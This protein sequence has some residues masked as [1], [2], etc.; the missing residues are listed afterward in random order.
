MYAMM[1]VAVAK[2]TGKACRAGSLTSCSCGARG[3]LPASN[4]QTQYYWGCSENIKHGLKVSEEFLDAAERDEGTG[5][6]EQV[7]LQ[8]LKAGRVLL[9]KASEETPLKCQCH[10]L[11]GTCS[12]KTCWKVTP[13]LYTIAQKLRDRYEKACQVE[14]AP[15]SPFSLSP[16]LTSTCHWPL[17][18]EDLVF[19]DASP[20]YCT[21]KTELGSLGTQGR[22]CDP[23]A[24][25]SR[26]ESCQHLCCGRG[27][28]KET[29]IVEYSCQCQFEYCC[30][31]NCQTCHKE[32][33]NYWCR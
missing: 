27:Y 31:L 30:R 19:S 2:H 8:N 32:V 25:A 10:G 11:T 22:K 4:S 9:E 7:H 18:E 24:P 28:V 12:L 15:K 3:T 13:P 14:Y 1:A 26:S 16:M 5:L 21:P 6:R 29:K 23:S 17:A 33:T 20:N